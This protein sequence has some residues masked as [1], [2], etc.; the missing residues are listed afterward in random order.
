[1]SNQETVHI[2]T[3]SKRPFIGEEFDLKKWE[4]LEPFFENLKNREINSA[5][6]LKQWFSDRSEIE[7][8]LSENFAWRYIRQTCDT[9]NPV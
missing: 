5:E 8:Y 6:D 7:S 9:A 4:D 2:P 3:R 1:M